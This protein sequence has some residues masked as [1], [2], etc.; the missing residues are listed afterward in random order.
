MRHHK[1]ITVSIP[2][3]GFD[4]FQ[5]S[6]SVTVFGLASTWFDSVLDSWL[7]ALRDD[8]SDTPAGRA[9]RDLHYQYYGV[10]NQLLP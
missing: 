6:N 3:C 5:E 7:E 2:N 1:V 4:I 9:G 10:L 8:Q